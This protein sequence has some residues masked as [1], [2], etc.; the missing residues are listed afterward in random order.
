MT[1]I[2]TPRV[3]PHPLPDADGLI[4]RDGYGPVHEITTVTLHEYTGLV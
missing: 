3:T 2:I 4:L 1:A